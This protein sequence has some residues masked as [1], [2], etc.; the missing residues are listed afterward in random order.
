MRLTFLSASALR[1]ARLTTALLQKT[2]QGK[3]VH[4]MAI[5]IQ[6]LGQGMVRYKVQ[7]IS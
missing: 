6:L 2:K 3:M 1:L 7:Y 4:T 5:H